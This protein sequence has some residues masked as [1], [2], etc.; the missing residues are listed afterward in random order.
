MLR[1]DTA[2]SAIIGLS[3]ATGAIVA[4]ATP[5]WYGL[6]T[7]PLGA[8]AAMIAGVLWLKARLEAAEKRESEN[9]TLVLSLLEKSITAQVKGNDVI[10]RNSEALENVVS[11]VEQMKRQ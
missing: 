7:G 4:S 10:E 1:F 2:M 5:D 8:V 9:R 11:A 3:G 6:V